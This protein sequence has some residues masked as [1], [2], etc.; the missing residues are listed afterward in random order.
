MGASDDAAMSCI[1]EDSTVQSLA[2]TGVEVCSYADDVPWWHWSVDQLPRATWQGPEDQWS[3]SVD[4]QI[5]R[6]LAVLYREFL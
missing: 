3:S 6:M 4:S 2:P 1:F 5:L